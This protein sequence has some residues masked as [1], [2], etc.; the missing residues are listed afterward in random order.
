MF[1]KSPPGDSVSFG[2]DQLIKEQTLRLLILT[3]AA[4]LILAG[5]VSTGGSDPDTQGAASSS[6]SISARSGDRRGGRDRRDG[7]SV[8]GTEDAR[9]WEAPVG[10]FEL[11]GADRPEVTREKSKL[12]KAGK[13]Y[14]KVLKDADPYIY[15]IYNEFKNREIPAELV[16]I[17][18]QESHFDPSAVSRSGPAGLWQFTPTTARGMGLRVGKG[19]DE[20]KDPL[21]STRAACEYLLRLNDEVG[22]DWLTTI[23]AYGMGPYN[24]KKQIKRR[25]ASGLPTDFWSLDIPPF[26]RKY[27]SRILAFADLLRN[28]ESNSYTLPDT[29]YR[30]Y[31]VYAD[32]GSADSLEEIAKKADLSLSE[33]RRLN[34]SV[35]EKTSL[36]KFNIRR[37]LAPV[38]DVDRIEKTFGDF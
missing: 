23:A 15:I 20:R 6:E 35:S 18:L 2:A 5:C 30:E 37:I 32:V 14:S 8:S 28:H 11:E 24:I 36:K 21:K 22:G 19:I 1:L 17:A 27:V 10:D 7:L 26:T 25:Q 4:C 29:P 9:I 33:L 34:I 13:Y 38:D 12:S 3:T 16:L 31:A